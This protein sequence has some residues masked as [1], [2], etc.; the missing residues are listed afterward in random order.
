MTNINSKYIDE[1]T[2]IDTLKITHLLVLFIFKD[3]NNKSLKISFNKNIFELLGKSTE[4]LSKIY[5]K[6][7]TSYI[8]FLVQ[9]YGSLNIPI[10]FSS[11]SFKKY[12]IGNIALIKNEENHNFLK[13]IIFKYIK[14]F[15]KTKVS[16]VIKL[17]V[18]EF[19]NVE[20]DTEKEI[21][22]YYSYL[23]EIL[24]LIFKERN[25]RLIQ[26]LPTVTN[27][28]M[29]LMSP[30]N[31]EL[32]SICMENSKKVL[33]CLI[34][35]YP[36][37]AFHQN[38]QKLAVGSVDGKIFIYEMATGSIW[39][40]LEA[41]KTQISA[42]IFDSSGN[43]IISY[44]AQEHLLKCWRI[45]LANFFGNLFSMKEYKSKK[46]PEIKKDIIPEV[47]LQNTKFQLSNKEGQVLLTREDQT[48]I[49]YNI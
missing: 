19:R 39:K 48:V 21:T 3:L 16:Y 1:L 49:D 25:H 28:I 20:D 23:V 24:W 32:K 44:S 12:E 14:Y 7:S 27:Q 42:L 11:N 22:N 41:H 6:N 10:N 30:A 40:S 46:L 31:K 18:D 2:D 36:M 37:I 5:H 13:I 43:F 9:Y 35:N 38:T 33:S 15:A 29:R 45:G 34:I 4:T 8:L 26:Y 47:I 17:I